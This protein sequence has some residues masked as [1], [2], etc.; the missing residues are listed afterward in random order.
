MGTFGGRVVGPAEV[1]PVWVHAMHLN[2]L[3]LADPDDLERVAA[4]CLRAANGGELDL[5]VRS[6]RRQYRERECHFA[7]L[8][9]LPL[10]LVE[11]NVGELFLLVA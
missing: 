1:E 8:V 2:K 3:V 9:R 10:V 11:D 4:P 7:E 6:P 5:V